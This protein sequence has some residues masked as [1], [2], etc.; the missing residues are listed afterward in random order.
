RRKYRASGAHTCP[1]MRG[2]GGI[3]PLGKG[4]LRAKYIRDWSPAYC[5][6]R[7]ESYQHDRGVARAADPAMG[8]FLSQEMPSI[9]G[10]RVYYSTANYSY[11]RRR[12][13]DAPQ[14][15]ADNGGSGKYYRRTDVRALCKLS[16]CA[17]HA[18]RQA[19]SES[20]TGSRELTTG[21]QSPGVRPAACS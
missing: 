20:A 3:H 21:P 1:A 18:F 19:G 14:A 11:G 7:G 15:L 10:I 16:V 8:G 6:D 9:L 5:A 13:S 4:L 12:R 2:D 17:R